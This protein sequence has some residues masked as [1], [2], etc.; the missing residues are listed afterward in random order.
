MSI[1]FAIFCYFLLEFLE[2]LVKWSRMKRRWTAP[3]WGPTLVRERDA[4]RGCIFAFCKLN[5]RFRPAA[6]RRCPRGPPALRRAAAARRK[7]S[8]R[9]SCRAQPAGEVLDEALPRLDIHSRSRTWEP[10]PLATL[11]ADPLLVRDLRMLGLV[12]V[13]GGRRLL[14]RRPRIEKLVATW[15]ALEKRTAAIAAACDASGGNSSKGWRCGGGKKRKKL[16]GAPGAAVPRGLAP[17]GEVL[18]PTLAPPPSKKSKK[19]K[20]KK[21]RLLTPD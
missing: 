17:P 9:L 4:L 13:V 7:H 3:R 16:G 10:A 2:L 15:E 14:A 5:A 20:K 19:K 11:R 8:R 18:A 21:R 1:K 6:H 12:L